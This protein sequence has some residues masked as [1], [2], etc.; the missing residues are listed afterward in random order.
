MQKTY[1]ILHI[2]ITIAAWFMLVFSLV[3]LLV[4]YKKLPQEIGVHFSA[5]GTFDLYDDKINAFY[6]YKVGFGV[7]IISEL[8]IWL[9][10]RIKSGLKV[11]EQG[12]RR[13]KVAAI[14]WIDLFK[15]SISVFFT[16][17]SYCVI[18]Q[19]VLSVLLVRVVIFTIGGG[20][21]LLILAAV[22]I[23]ILNAG[24]K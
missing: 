20:L 6:P 11:D 10:K 12:E 23:R 15:C 1:K 19:S 16:H 18:T 21:L 8:A 24:K 22:A 7:L 9:A 14:L 5:S 4:I 13:L 2:T 3:Y 17:W